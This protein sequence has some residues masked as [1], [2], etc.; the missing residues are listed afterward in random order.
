[1]A[2]KVCSLSYWL[3]QFSA[4]VQD[5]GGAFFMETVTDYASH[6]LHARPE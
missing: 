1:M 6:A 5:Y 2:L 4:K 3:R